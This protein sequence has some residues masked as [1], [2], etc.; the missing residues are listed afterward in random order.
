V[1][2]SKGAVPLFIAKLRGQKIQYAALDPEPLSIV[3]ANHPA[4]DDFAE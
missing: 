2:S 1:A 4:V 3:L